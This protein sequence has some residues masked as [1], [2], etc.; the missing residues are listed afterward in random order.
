VTSVKR[1]DDLGTAL[2]AVRRAVDAAVHGL[3]GTFGG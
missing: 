3:R 2:A 1:G